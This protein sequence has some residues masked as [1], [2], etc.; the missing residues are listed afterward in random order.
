M[1]VMP[2]SSI[3]QSTKSVK[4]KLPDWWVGA[5]AGKRMMRVIVPR[6]CHTV[7][8]PLIHPMRRVDRQLSSPWQIRM[9]A[10]GGIMNHQKAAFRR[11]HTAR[12]SNI[13]CATL[14]I[15]CSRC[16]SLSLVPP[17]SEAAGVPLETR[18]ERKIWGGQE[19]GRSYL[20]LPSNEE[21][22]QPSAAISREN[23]GT[24]LFL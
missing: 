5:T 23:R 24:S 22:P 15:L 11:L 17:H 21:S 12:Q 1:L 10:K 4:T 8:I 20:R 7:E 3:C 16:S 14:L 13:S 19:E 9:P 6:M 18:S 2:V